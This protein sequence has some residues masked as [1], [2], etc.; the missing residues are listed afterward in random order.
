MNIYDNLIMLKEQFINFI[1]FPFNRLLILSVTAQISSMF[2]KLI[3]NA[4]RSKKISYKKMATY[5]GMPSSHT[6]FVMA[7]VFGIGF[8]KE[9]GWRD[10][11]FTI[12]LVVAMIVI[13][14]AVRLRGTVDRLKNIIKQLVE[15]DK[16]LN[17][18]V[19]IPK[20]IAHTSAEVIGGIVFAFL[21]TLVFYLFFYNFF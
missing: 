9:F 15:N 11:L 20:N 14:D 16:E 18:K 12:S 7:A 10:P 13:I 8:D 3:I 5:G 17:G 2:A 4:V 6:A 21:Y 1:Y 19:V